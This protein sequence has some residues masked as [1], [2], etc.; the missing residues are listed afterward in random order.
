MF[1]EVVKFIKSLH[2]ERVL[3]RLH[4]TCIK[5]NEKKC[6]EE[7]IDSNYVSYIG[8]FVHAFEKKIKDHLLNIPSSVKSSDDI[9][10]V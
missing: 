3:I 8:K 1:K 5:G 2:T 9:S 10:S 6:M 7:C 4:E